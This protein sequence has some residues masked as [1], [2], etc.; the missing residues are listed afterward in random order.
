MKTVF[1]RSTSAICDAE[2]DQ[3]KR[4]GKRVEV[5]LRS[6]RDCRERIAGNNLEWGE[7]GVKGS[8]PHAF[9]GKKVTKMKKE[10]HEGVR[11][12]NGPGFTGKGRENKGKGGGESRK[13]SQ[14]AL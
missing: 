11:I 1:E 9:E 4:L 3:N 2:V 8:L 12:G 10:N 6:Q 5:L 7:R 13:D 14:E